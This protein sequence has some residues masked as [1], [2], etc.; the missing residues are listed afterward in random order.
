[1]LPA[2]TGVVD[3]APAIPGREASSAQVIAELKK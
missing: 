3:S 2:M 1:M